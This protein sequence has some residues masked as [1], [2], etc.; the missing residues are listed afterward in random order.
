M[1]ATSTTPGARRFSR[2]EDEAS[3]RGAGQV[4]GVHD[5]DTRQPADGEREDEA[6]VKNGT[7]A[8]A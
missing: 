1:V 2:D 3:E 8:S 7:A 4:G 6:P 5:V